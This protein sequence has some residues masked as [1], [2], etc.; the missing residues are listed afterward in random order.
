MAASFL[1]CPFCRV[2]NNTV[3]RTESGLWRL[4][5]RCPGEKTTITMTADTVEE[6]I[7]KWNAGASSYDNRV[8]LLSIREVYQSFDKPIWLETDEFPEGRYSVPGK[9]R[10]EWDVDFAYFGTDEYDSFDIDDYN[11]TWFPYDRKPCGR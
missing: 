5:H 9:S 1:P 4:A 2:V 11:K 8:K 7:E 3:E 6:L 10:R